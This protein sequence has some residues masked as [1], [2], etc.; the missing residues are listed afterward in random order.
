MQK[1][2]QALD[3]VRYQLRQPTA[4]MGRF[5]DVFEDTAKVDP[6]DLIRIDPHRPV[7]KIQRPDI[8]EPKH[9]ID[10]AVRY[11]HRVE[12]ADVGPQRLLT[13]IDRGIDEYLLVLVLDKDRNPQ[14]LVPRVLR[15]ARLAIARDRRNAGRCAC[16]EKGKFHLANFNAENAKA[17]EKRKISLPCD[18]CGRCIETIFFREYRHLRIFVRLVPLVFLLL[19]GQVGR[20]ASAGRQA[21]PRAGEPPAGE[22]FLW[23]YP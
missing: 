7:T 5:E 20:T 21:G 17:A 4:E 13:K 10:V 1:G 9:M 2:A 18:L 19:R 11:Q 3:S 16:A 6:R 15:Q 23:F 8:V 14:A 22:G 12:M